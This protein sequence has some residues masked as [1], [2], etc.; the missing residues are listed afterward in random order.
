MPDPITHAGRS[1]LP[2]LQS[3]SKEQGLSPL[4]SNLSAL[5]SLIQG[6]LKHL[7]E[8]INNAAQGKTLVEK[9]ARELLALSG[10]RLRPLCVLLAAH[11][12]SPKNQDASSQAV[13]LKNQHAS[14]WDSACQ[15]GVA[16]E[17]IHNATLL[18]DD[19]VDLADKRRG[20]P[21]VRTIY[22][23]ALSIFAGDWLL[24]DALRRVEK[25][26]ISFLLTR[27]L[28]T[29]EEMIFAE[30]LQLERR[31]IIEP[32]REIYFQ[33]IEGKTAS[34]FRWALFAGGTIANLSEAECQIL[35]EYGNLIGVSF[36]LVD[37]ALDFVGDS[38]Q[39][40]KLRFADLRE[41]K[42]TY[43][44]LV[45]LEKDPSL[46]NLLTQYI[47]AKEDLAS[48]SRIEDSIVKRV[49]ELGG[50]EECRS[51]ARR[52]VAQANQLLANFPKSPSVETLLFVAEES[53]LRKL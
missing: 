27:L 37:D 19:V 52:N 17:L 21:A 38:V 6:Q 29:I 35:A 28:S 26:G 13:S 31:G 25:V 12:G 22:G 18:H 46:K 23:N 40:G 36:Q 9:A 3:M 2:K 47:E 16:V 45:A 11:M 43:P 10:K 15:L 5:Q 48:S 30:S 53:L 50:V 41:G 51:L 1:V 42:M 7:Q 44:L 24:I 39:M 4:E 33:V 34:L 32:S 20:A 8:E 14:L 49:L